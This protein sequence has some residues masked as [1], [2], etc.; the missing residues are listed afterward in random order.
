MCKILYNW[1]YTFLSSLTLS[2]WIGI[3]ALFVTILTVVPLFIRK[4]QSQRTIK[5]FLVGCS[6][7]LQRNIDNIET[8]NNA[9]LQNT[10]QTVELEVSLDKLIEEFNALPLSDARA[11]FI[12][13]SGKDASLEKVSAFIGALQ[14]ISYNIET[15][16]RMYESGLSAFQRD[17]MN[18]VHLFMRLADI[19]TLQNNNLPALTTLGDFETQFHQIYH[20]WLRQFGEISDNFT[21]SDS[22][23]D[24]FIL[25][26]HVFTPLAEA[27]RVYGLSAFAID[28]MDACRRFSS[29]MGL[30]QGERAFFVGRLNIL[31][32]Q[33]RDVRVE[34]DK[35]ISL[36]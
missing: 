31:K 9:I 4:L 8:H 7:R 30:W 18:A 17:A 26:E 23:V 6:A 29:A 12:F 5:D 36:M 32:D 25:E 16:H 24:P 2:D 34:L 33:I 10:L 20:N 27:F 13:R 1:I 11:L 14:P 21:T 35:L 28:A 3:I 22:A 19:L 15:S